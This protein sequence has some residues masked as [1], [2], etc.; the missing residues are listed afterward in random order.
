MGRGNQITRLLT[1]IQMLDKRRHG[2]V[3]GELAR[4]LNCHPR[5]IHRDLDHLEAAGLPLVNETIGG[6]KHWQ[7]I[8]GYKT[9][10]PTPF[11]LK[12][13]MSLYLA[14][15]LLKNLEG[16]FFYESIYDLLNKI[17]TQLD[18]S[19]IDFLYSTEHSF[20]AGSGPQTDYKAHR[21]LLNLLN[22]ACLTCEEIT[23]RYHSRKDELTTRK[24]Q[25]YK[26]YFYQGTLY[27]I[28]Y[29]LKRED[30][31][32]FVID[33]IKIL[34]KSGR[35]FKK[36]ADFDVHDYLKHSFGVMREDLIEVTVRVAAKVARFIAEKKWHASQKEQKNKDGSMDFSFLVAGTKEIKQWILGLGPMATVLDPPELADEIV[37]GLERT[38]QNYRAT[39]KPSRQK[40]G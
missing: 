17:R 13:L 24:V 39:G 25:P 2:I 28:G 33:R 26:V 14:R 36:P 15:D 38:L 21:E 20:A 16:T 30:M 11:N 23:F 5:T 7:F 32:T 1:I 34:Q 9:S 31:R 35:K 22:D 27:L 37:E 4:E 18:P 8:D 40:A 10:L 6:V 29:D 3:V 12:E 19:L